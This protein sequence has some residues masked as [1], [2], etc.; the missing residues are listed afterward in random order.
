[1]DWPTV[2]VIAIVA[3]FVLALGL[4]LVEALFWSHGQLVAL[5]RPQGRIKE[6]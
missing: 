6:V 4:I 1:M 5:G 2:V 3:L